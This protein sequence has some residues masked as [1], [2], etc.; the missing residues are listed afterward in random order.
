MSKLTGED[1]LMNVRRLRRLAPSD[2][3]SDRSRSHRARKL[4]RTRK[5]QRAL[6]APPPPRYKLSDFLTDSLETSR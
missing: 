4:T 5:L 2:V 3:R 1:H 6:R